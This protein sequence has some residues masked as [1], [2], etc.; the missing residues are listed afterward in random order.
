VAPPPLR[1]RRDPRLSA[2]VRARTPLYYTEGADPALDRPA[3]ARSGSSL[4]WFRGRLAVVQDDAHFIA[5]VDPDTRHVEAVPLPADAHGR[6]L[7]DD[8]RGT[9]HLKMDL[10]AGVV[11][12]SPTGERLLALGSGST[13][14]RERIAVLENAYGPARIIHA[15]ALYATL[16]Q[17]RAF[18]GSELNVE[19]ALHLGDHLRLFN[20][21]NGAPRDG[22]MP[23]DATCDL[24]WD[25][26]AAYLDAPDRMPPPPPERIVAYALG[27][28]AG[29]RLTFTDASATH[30]GLLYCASAE[31]S[32]DAV[33]DGEVMGTAV[34]TLPPDAP[35]RWAPLTYPD[36]SPCVE[37]VEG[38]CP[39]RIRPGLLY[40]VT[41][42][43]AP[44]APAELCEVE[45]RG[46]WQS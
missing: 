20:R 2:V 4:V 17:A 36:G 34:G 8:L 33:E 10:E 45:L 41:D 15:E 32:P 31:D 7:F 28:L 30:F 6:R 37:K 19:G 5:L 25:A 18:S 27:A 9:K 39:S 26:L 1:A 13:H 24:R 22:I 38:L 35:P 29:I 46:P 3:S 21:G 16:R 12:P 11:V 43:D 23:V 42:P 14:A 40:L 44:R